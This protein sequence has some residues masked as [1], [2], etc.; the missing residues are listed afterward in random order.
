MRAPTPRAFLVTG[1]LALTAAAPALVASASGVLWI[2]R[3][4]IGLLAVWAALTSAG[5]FTFYVEAFAKRAPDAHL[6]WVMFPAALVAVV[7]PGRGVGI[8]AASWGSFV[9]MSALA[10]RRTRS[11]PPLHRGAHPFARSDR[12]AA[13]ALVVAGIIA[14]LAGAA[15]AVSEEISDVLYVF[16]QGQLL[17]GPG[18]LVG[19]VAAYVVLP[20][21]AKDPRVTFGATYVFTAQ[22]VAALLLPTV[23][24]LFGMF[25]PLFAAVPFTVFVARV[26]LARPK[27]TQAKASLPFFAAGAVF[28][29]GAVPADWARPGLQGLL[30][31]EAIGAGLLL[32]AATYALAPVVVNQVPW[33]RRLVIPL[34]AL[35]AVGGALLVL[36]P[37][38]PRG[39]SLRVAGACIL[40]LAM[41]GHALNLAP[42]RRP[43]RD[44]PPDLVAP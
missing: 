40:A 13:A 38:V 22:A 14:I 11:T 5:L 3:A 19:M 8:L 21:V 20:R 1:T 10:G 35:A 12:A 34:A 9:L 30:V 17:F 7:S 25:A 16:P 37:D 41:V 18:V 39:A 36:G 2:E 15:T 23:L 42:M 26:L 4:L 24:F 29:V 32:V 33:S 6:A 28:L 27:G 44:C 43:R 31:A